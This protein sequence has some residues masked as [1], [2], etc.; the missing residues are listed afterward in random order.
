MSIEYPT[1][2]ENGS[3]IC[4]ITVEYKWIYIFKY[5]SL[6]FLVNPFGPQTLVITAFFA[7][8]KVLPCTEFHIVGITIN[9][10]FDGFPELCET[11]L[12]FYICMFWYLIFITQHFLL[13]I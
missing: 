2:F 4:N 9:K 7:A 11:I 6:L 8:S 5:I 1:D 3:Y 12:K 13:A 10:S